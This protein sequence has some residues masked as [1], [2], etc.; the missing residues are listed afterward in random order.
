MHLACVHHKQLVVDYLEGLLSEMDLADPGQV[1]R[2]LA[3]LVDGAIVNAH[4]AGDSQA[5]L[6]AKSAALVLLESYR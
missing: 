1:A 5:A 3:L 4:T 2:Q 6:T